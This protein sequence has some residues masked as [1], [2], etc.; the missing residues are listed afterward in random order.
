MALFNRANTPQVRKKIIHALSGAFG[1]NVDEPTSFDGIPVLNS[2]NALFYDIEKH[3][4]EDLDT[5]WELF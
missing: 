5:L 4:Q 2:I 3:T 1:T